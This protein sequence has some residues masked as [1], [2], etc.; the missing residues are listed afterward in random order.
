MGA[1][2]WR[3]FTTL[4]KHA[5][6][7]AIDDTIA[8][9]HEKRCAIC[10]TPFLPSRPALL[11]AKKLHVNQN[12]CS[13]LSPYASQNSPSNNHLSLNSANSQPLP[14]H[15]GASSSYGASSPYGAFAYADNNIR[16]S[17][18]SEGVQPKGTHI[19]PS[20]IHEVTSTIHETIDNE[21]SRQPYTQT[22]SQLPLAPLWYQAITTSTGSLHEALATRCICPQCVMQLPRILTGHCPQCGEI[23]PWP[24]APKTL[25]L[26]CLT[27]P[28]VWE[29][30]HFHAPYTG[31]LRKMILRHK[32]SANL[33]LGSILGKLMAQH[34]DIAALSFDT[35]IPVPLHPKRLQ[36]RGYNQAMEIAKGLASQRQDKAKI[37]AHTLRR[38]HPTRP[39]VGLSQAER[40]TNV[41]GAFTMRHSVEGRHILLID[42]VYTTGSTLKECALVLRQA[43]A[44]SIHVATVARADRHQRG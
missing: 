34:P 2:S 27:T 40:K 25:C 23:S 36:E 37:L 15:Q 7:R 20:T 8:I 10:T 44:A 19:T 30:Y 38:T 5:A 26:T 22:Q 21:G 31:L 17:S 32:F 16:Q 9:I 18:F 35:I 3:F 13:S 39:Q 14:L 1:S 6:T 33:S 11:S 41:R 24:L 28:P 12:T 43:K 29:S 4:L 42:D